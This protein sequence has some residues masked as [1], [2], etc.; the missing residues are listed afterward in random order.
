[1]SQNITLLYVEEDADLRKQMADMLREY[2]VRILT[3]DNTLS[4]YDQFR[5]HKIDILLV[6]CK[7]IH[8]NGIEFIRHIRQKNIFIPIIITLMDMKKE[9]LLEA[10]NLDISQCLIKPY[11]KEEMLNALEK[12]AKK[13]LTCHPLSNNELDHGFSY[14]P[15]NK[16]IIRPDG[17]SV[18][19]SRK[20][21]IFIEL[22]L[23]NK[24]QIIPYEQIERSIWSESSMSMD[25]LRTLVRSVRKKTYPDI[26][27]NHNGIGYKIDF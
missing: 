3:A 18:Q 14:D 7:N 9:I 25:A 20:E 24:R 22:L 23:H 1:M 19:L 27:S 13:V 10:I 15:I 2:G 12:A 21:Y 8:N 17:T 6:D 4:A 11:S 16:S 5:T 26:I